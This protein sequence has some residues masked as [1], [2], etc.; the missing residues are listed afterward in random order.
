MKIDLDFR[1]Q[2]LRL[3]VPDNAD[4]LPLP[5]QKPL[6]N[7][8]AAVQDAIA[9]PIGTPSLSETVRA[10]VRPSGTRAVIV[11]SDNTRP[12]PYRGRGGILV[13]ILDVLKAEGVAAIDILVAT[14][15]HHPLNRDELAEILPPQ[16][17]EPPVTIVN[18]V[19][20]DRD[21]LRFLGRTP[22]GTE[23]WINA[24]YLDADVKIL[25]G[26]AEPHFMA[27]VSGGRKSIC[28]GLAGEAVTHMFHGAKLMGDPN[29]DSLIID[30]NPCHNEAL[31]VA[32]KAGAD[33][34]VNVAVDRDGH[35]TGVFCGHMEAAHAEAVA[36][37]TR[38]QGIPVPH[39]YDLVVTQAGFAGINHY[40]AAKAGVEA[41]KAVKPGGTILLA[42]NHTDRDTVGGANYKRTLKLLDD[43]G[44]EGFE[45]RIR[46][47]DWE[48]VPEQ[49]Q[50]QMW[51]KVFRK[52]GAMERLIYCS[53]QVS[54]DTFAEH[55]LPGIDG[56]CGVTGHTAR[57]IAE[58]GVQQQLDG[59]LQTH[60]H[61]LV[62]VL[63]DGPYGVPIPLAK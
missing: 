21:S 41:A 17:F 2:T 28:P 36:H 9:N 45:A 31:D 32:R 19:A 30:G 62:A 22:R 56:C 35:L 52:T 51:C 25:T 18:H 10:K 13:P 37:V 58:H 63:P 11:I 48:F 4:V 55:A 16:A 23:A 26:L 40:Q 15:T 61:A 20:T 44:P 53:P 49:W 38:T 27:G 14:G 7:P 1:S 29:S 43:L 59:F 24:R 33:F 42:A 57:D 47:D 54:G 6:V 8:D 3:D 50:V 60:P 12:V 46:Q 34:I 5:P 39:L